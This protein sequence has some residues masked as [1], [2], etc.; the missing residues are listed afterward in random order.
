MSTAA[1]A[2]GPPAWHLIIS[3]LEA[4]LEEV[5]AAAAHLQPAPVQVGQECRAPYPDLGAAFGLCERAQNFWSLACDAVFL[6]GEGA[7]PPNEEE[8][9]GLSR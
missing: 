7:S 6:V 1:Q 2:C 4:L 9:Q 5:C 3:E 8:S